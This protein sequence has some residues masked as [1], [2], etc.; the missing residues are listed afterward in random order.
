MMQNME[1]KKE[2][3]KCAYLLLNL[4]FM[5]IAHA[6]REIYGTSMIII[7]II[8]RYFFFTVVSLD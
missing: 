3:D 7:R 6:G 2:K 5:F 1:R 8:V 4:S